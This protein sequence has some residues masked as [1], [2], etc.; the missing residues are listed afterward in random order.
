MSEEPSTTLTPF[1][2]VGGAEPVRQLVDKFYDHMELHE[3]VLADLHRRDADGKI[4]REFRD[5]FAL[6][7][8]GWLGGPQEYMERHGHPRLRM[9]HGHV[10]VDQAM[11]AAWMRSMNA[12]MDAQ[13]FTGPVRGFLDRRFADVADFLRNVAE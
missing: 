7:L 10:P 1:T 2:L 6:F 9:R 3:P 5:R 11:K 8:I 4:S 12:A 13:N